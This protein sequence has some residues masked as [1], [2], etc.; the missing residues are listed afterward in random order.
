MKTKR[1][2]LA[3]LALAAAAAGSWATLGGPA[4]A[5]SGNVLVPTDGAY[6]KECGTCHHA[7]SPE[8]LP[9][10]SWR[11]VMQ[12]LDDHFGD[13]A[14]VD[15][16]T[17]RAI[18]DY[19]IANAADRATNGQSRAIMGSLRPGEAPLRITQVPYIAGLH[20]TVLDPLWNGTPRPK[21]LTECGVCHNDVKSGDFN[22]RVFH[23]NDEL[24][25]GDNPRA[26]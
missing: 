13:P 15:A 20:A 8:L 16:A 14:R 17:Q 7:F 23:V 12:R 21:T 19:L 10:A 3:A 25:R 18:T 22:S 1:Q 6:L 26:R 2:G 5:A 4:F 24:F 9:A 11:G